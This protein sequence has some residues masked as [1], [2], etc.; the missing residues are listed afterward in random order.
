[1]A[2]GISAPFIVLELVRR[3]SFAASRR[4]RIWNI[5]GLVDFAVAVS[6]GTLCSGFFPEITRL[7]G[8]VTTSPMTHLPLV[9]VPAYMVP[10]FAMLH[11]TALFQTRQ[12]ARSEKSA[13][14]FHG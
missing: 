14:G 13:P 9:L 3:P 12:L 8:N 1:M 2:I 7:V 10:F 6:M 4:Y 11:F 5:F